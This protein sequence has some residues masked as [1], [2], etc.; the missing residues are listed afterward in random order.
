MRRFNSICA[1]LAQCV[2][3]N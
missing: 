3:F 1:D 2:R